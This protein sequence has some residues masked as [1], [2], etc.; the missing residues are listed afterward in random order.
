MSSFKLSILFR[1]VLLVWC[2]LPAAPAHGQDLQALFFEPILTGL[3]LPVSI[4][5]PDDGSGWMYA[6]EQAGR[7]CVYDGLSLQ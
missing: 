5:F 4:A 6:V 7:V 2:G 1:V 3:E